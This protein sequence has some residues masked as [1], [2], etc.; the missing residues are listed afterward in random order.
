G[1]FQATIRNGQRLSAARAFLAPIKQRTNLTIATGGIVTRIIFHACRAI[2]VACTV[3]GTPQQFRAD[4]EVILC[5]GALQ[6]PKILQLSGIGPG[7]RLHSLKIPVICDSPG[8]AQT[9]PD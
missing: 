5:A 2:G 3:N 7:N 1:Y 4:R 8:G 9:L 6:S